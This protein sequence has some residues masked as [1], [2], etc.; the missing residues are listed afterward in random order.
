MDHLRELPKGL[1]AEDQVHVAIGL[2]DLLSHVLL[3]HHAAAQADELLR[4]AALGV[5]QGAHVAEHPLLGVLPD[6]AG[7]EDDEIRLLHILRQGEAALGQHPHELLPVGHI[8][9]AAE[10]IHAGPGMG[11]TGFKHA[12][13]LLLKVPLAGK[14][15]RRDQYVFA[16]QNRSSKFRYFN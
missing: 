13:D 14:V 9:L 5:D 16:F 6:G 8:L 1:G 15:L 10:G 7:V 12:A 3:L 4:V 11:L 2:A